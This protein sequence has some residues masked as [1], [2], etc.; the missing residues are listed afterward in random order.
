MTSLP[1]HRARCNA[2]ITIRAGS[3]GNVAQDLTPTGELVTRI[4]HREDPPERWAVID[5]ADPRILISEELLGTLLMPSDRAWYVTLTL[6]KGAR[7][8]AW[9]LDDSESPW[10]VDFTYVTEPDGRKRIPRADFTG[11]ILRVEA[12]NRTVVYRVM[13]YAGSGTWLAEWPD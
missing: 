9:F 8:P 2:N 10:T 13:R 4:E 3:G 6:A 1:G 5:R 7:G 11:A 12:Q